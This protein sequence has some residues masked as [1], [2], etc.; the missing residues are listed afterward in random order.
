MTFP[1]CYSGVTLLLRRDISREKPGENRETPG[2][3]VLGIL[4]PAIFYPGLVPERVTRIYC[5][6]AD[7]ASFASSSTSGSLGS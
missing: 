6:N 1:D 3:L 5:L 4:T 2:E 7:L